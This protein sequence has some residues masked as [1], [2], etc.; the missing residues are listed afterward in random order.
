MEYQ[1]FSI[2]IS[3]TRNTIPLFDS[4]TECPFELYYSAY[5]NIPDSNII[6]ID[7][8]YYE[9]LMEA[10]C[11][12]HITRRVPNTY[13]EDLEEMIKQL[14]QIPIAPS[15]ENG[16]FVRSDTASL[17]YGMHGSK[18][19]SCW[20]DIIDSIVTCRSTHHPITKPFRLYF[21]P[22]KNIHNEFRIFIYNS[23]IVGIS[24]SDIYS[25]SYGILSKKDQMDTYLKKLVYFVENDILPKKPKTV[26]HATLDIAELED[27]SFYFI[28][29]NRYSSSGSAGF[30]WSKDTFLYKPRNKSDK[31]P[32]RYVIP[33]TNI[34]E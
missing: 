4:T 23:T 29:M 33:T 27:G 28:E 26:S 14:P 5:H 19:Y 3:H 6:I 34:D 30:E 16:W 9:L 24:V 10:L 7:D 31:I 11:I 13:K 17:K 22:Y 21:L 15:P 2:D 1:P 12:G 32:F 18:P 8:K 20:K 25:V